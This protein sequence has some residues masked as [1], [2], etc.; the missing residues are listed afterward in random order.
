MGLNAA[1]QGSVCV[2]CQMLWRQQP[3]LAFRSCQRR[4]TPQAASAA[5]LCDRVAQ[6]TR[7]K[8]GISD[9][10]LGNGHLCDGAETSRSP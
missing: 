3:G 8:A 2:V 4:V 7:I 5:L 9:Q 10:A 1:G 6:A